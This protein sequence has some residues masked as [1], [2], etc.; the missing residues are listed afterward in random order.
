MDVHGSLKP[1]LLSWPN[2]NSTQTRLC[3][4]FGWFTITS[5][6]RNHSKSEKE[7][8]R[9]PW[10]LIGDNF[11]AAFP[12]D[13]RDTCVKFLELQTRIAISR[14]MQY[15]HHLLEVAQFLSL[16]PEPENSPLKTD[17]LSPLWVG[18]RRQKSKLLR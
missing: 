2:H 6:P 17:F 3:N 7:L 10:V 14:N 8:H 5:Y 1:T 12:W 16:F 15:K 9:S 4:P 13:L 18:R 11:F